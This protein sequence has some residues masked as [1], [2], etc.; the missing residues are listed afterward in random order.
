MRLAVSSLVSVALLALIAGTVLANQP[1]PLTSYF[2]ECLGRSPKNSTADP[3]GQYTFHGTL[4]DGTG[5]P[6]PNYPASSVELEIMGGCQN[7]VILNPDGPSDANG[8]I[9]WGVN[10]L[11]QGG[12]ACIG[13]GV[14]DIRVNVQSFATLD[15]V[16]SP[17]EDGDTFVALSDLQAW[18]VAFVAQAPL[19]QGDLDCDTFIALS[20]LSRWQKHFVAP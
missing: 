16:R 17:D 1:D 18:Q 8:N 6:V 13:S 5:A 4:N 10:T 3:T 14:V 7:P 11:N 9:V 20:D 15:D 12:G 2:D 19:Y